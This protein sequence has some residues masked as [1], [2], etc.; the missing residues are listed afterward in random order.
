MIRQ[1]I[2]DHLPFLLRVGRNAVI[3]QAIAFEKVRHQ[4]QRIQ[5][6]GQK[7]RALQ[8]LFGQSEDIIDINKPNFGIRV[9]CGICR[10]KL[11]ASDVLLMKCPRQI[12]CVEA[13]DSLILALWGISLRGDRRD[14]A[15]SLARHCEMDD[16]QK[17]TWPGVNKW[18]KY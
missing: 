6:D 8:S 18:F 17:S 4:P 16:Q 9:T 2:P 3:R 10:T 11:S 13:R 14:S 5:S 7:V 1:K 15:A 12:K